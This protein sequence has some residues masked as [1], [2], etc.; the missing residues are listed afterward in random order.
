M[1]GQISKIGFIASMLSVVLSLYIYFI[2]TD[3]LLGIFV[4]L[5]APTLIL[6]T[7][8]IESLLENKS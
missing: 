7:K 6:A 8:E 1:S 4:G 3:Q 2:S 5:W